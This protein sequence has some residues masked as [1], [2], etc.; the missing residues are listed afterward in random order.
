MDRLNYQKMNIK[1]T[2]DLN[3][4][5]GGFY[6]YL[7]ETAY[8]LKQVSSD[9]KF[10]AMSSIH[11]LLEMTFRDIA[12]VYANMVFSPVTGVRIESEK[13]CCTM[14]RNKLN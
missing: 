9:P 2:H 7:L 13:D 6:L 11:T 8:E 5:M 10:K 3:H 1:T 14:L 12:K 4:R